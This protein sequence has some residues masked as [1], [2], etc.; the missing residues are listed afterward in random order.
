[1]VA[2][3][4]LTNVHMENKLAEDEAYAKLAEADALGR[5]MAQAFMDEQ[6]KLAAAD[7]GDVIPESAG[8]KAQRLLAAQQ[9]RARGEGMSSTVARARMGESSDPRRH[10]GKAVRRELAAERL[11][12]IKSKQG[13]MA[14]L[15]AAGE[16]LRLQRGLAGKGMGGAAKAVLETAKKHPG[17]AGA[18]GAGGLL[19]A[20]GAAYGV[21][22]L[23]DKK[24]FDEEALEMARD[25][26][27][28]NGIDPDT[29]DKLASDDDVA[30]RAAEILAEAGWL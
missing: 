21:K 26:L 27:L 30:E 18:V 11:A 6:A 17:V 4:D 5:Y 22:K 10:T 28:E 29:G 3:V 9:R 24:S 19:A 13:P 20:G 14:H 2:G 16:E 23:M 1:M 15:R 7:L 12:R 8:E 25:Y